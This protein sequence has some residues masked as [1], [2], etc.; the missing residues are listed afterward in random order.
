[1]PTWQSH[2]MVPSVNPLGP[3][4]YDVWD[5]AAL[6]EGILQAGLYKKVVVSPEVNAIWDP[7]SADSI[8]TAASLAQW[9]ANYAKPG[10][11]TTEPFSSIIFPI[12]DSLE[13]VRLD[14]TQNAPFVGV[15]MSSLMWR[16][17]IENI[18]P[19]RSNGMIVVFDDS[20]GPPF[21]YRLD[22]PKAIYLGDGDL[23]E[24]AFDH[25]CISASLPQLIATSESSFT[26][27][28]LSE[29]Y[30]PRKIHIY[31]S[32]DMKD[33]NTSQD[34]MLFTIAAALIFLFTSAVFIVYDFWVN[35]RQ[36]IVLKRALASGAIVSSLFPQQVREQLYEEK[37]KAEEKKKQARIFAFQQ[38]GAIGSPSKSRPIANVFDVSSAVFW[39]HFLRRY[40]F[41][42]IVSL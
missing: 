11:D 37:E 29:T 31:P 5:V 24:S 25:L 1:M 36:G 23:H 35:R 8:A 41:F 10:V 20:C 2:P 19:E 32:Q 30:C 17:L 42:C 26:G 16:V 6:G 28:P 38:D 15:L 39:V 4:N 9:A 21:T 12:Y 22:G 3:I 7:T 13:N 33:D 40:F 18:L 34:P 27:L 14:T